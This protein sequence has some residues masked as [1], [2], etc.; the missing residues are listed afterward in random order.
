MTGAI[1]CILPG[2]VVAGLLYFT[3]P[4]IVER[5]LGVIEA[6]QTSFE[7]TKR[8]WFMF[9]LWAIVVNLLAQLGVVACGVGLLASFPLLFTMASIAYRDTFGVAGARQFRGGQV[10]PP[11][12]YAPQTWSQPGQPEP[13]KPIP[14]P[15]I[16]ETNLQ[17]PRCGARLMSTSAK[18]CNICGA[19]LQA[20]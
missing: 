15:R 16:E 4:L 6:L 19:N 9:T 11:S 3:I 14:P 20:S 13:P 10:P 8:A 5:N 2:L 18:F 12:A 17:C 7:K 1:F